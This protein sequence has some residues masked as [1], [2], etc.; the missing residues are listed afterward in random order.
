MIVILYFRLDKLSK[1]WIPKPINCI[2]L[3]NQT[4]WIDYPTFLLHVSFAVMFNLLLFVTGKFTQPNKLS[5][6]L[7]MSEV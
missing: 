2:V 3:Q 6:K 5:N 7:N 1:N 4:N